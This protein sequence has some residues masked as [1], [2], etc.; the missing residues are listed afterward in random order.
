MCLLKLS[1]ISSSSHV[2]H[3]GTYRSL[4]VEKTLCHARV[5][6]PQK[7]SGLRKLRF[8]FFRSFLFAREQKKRGEKEEEEE[9]EPSGRSRRR[10]S[11]FICDSRRSGT[12]AGFGC[13]CQVYEGFATGAPATKP[14]VEA[15]PESYSLREVL[16]IAPNVRVSWHQRIVQSLPSFSLFLLS[17]S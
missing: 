15:C 17:L 4:G 14:R 6:G 5:C 2:F 11:Y 8:L 9:E 12:H 7:I 10:R 13:N 1:F 16:L 3:L